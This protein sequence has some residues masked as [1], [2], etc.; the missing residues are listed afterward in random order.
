MKIGMRLDGLQVLKGAV[1]PSFR[2][3]KFSRWYF[4]NDGVVLL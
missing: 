3:Q 4:W 1:L 2:C